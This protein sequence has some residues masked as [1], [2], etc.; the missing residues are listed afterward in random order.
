MT[1]LVY[2]EHDNASLKSETAKMVHAAAKMGGDIHVL[3]AGEGCQ[4]VADSAAKIDGVSKVL[5][6]DNAVYK[7]QL[8]E[9]VADLVLSLA[10]DY[11][12]LL[13]AATTTGKN[14]MPRVAA[15]LDVAQISDIIGVES[16]DT[17]IRPIYAGNAIATVQSSDSKKVITVRAA[18]FDA[19]TTGGSAEV[20][21]LDVVKVSEKSS[22]VSEELTESERPELTAAEVVISG[23][24]GMQNGENFKLLEGI[25][26]KL[27]AA[28][29]ASRAA[30]DAGFVPNDMQV[31]QTGKIVAPQ[32]YIAVGISGAIQ[33]LAGMK[34]SKVIVAINKDEEA[35]IFQVAD[36]GLVGDLFDVLPELENTL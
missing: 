15:L 29:G 5:L 12:H 22:F 2:A 7:Y 21:T 9:N 13:A 8:A 36:Y 34:D 25:A 17:F 23:G 30:V 11:S 6:I 10:D 1:V 27:G 19:A 24:R 26:D 18:S 32:L 3:V 14:F 28:I 33:H 20:T 16:E 4:A 31:G 35:P